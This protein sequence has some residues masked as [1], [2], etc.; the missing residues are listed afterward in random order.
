MTF[1]GT[2]ARDAARGSMRD[3]KGNG[4]PALLNRL[5]EMCVV[6]GR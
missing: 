5:A 6:C 3:S 1:S 4:L 2:A